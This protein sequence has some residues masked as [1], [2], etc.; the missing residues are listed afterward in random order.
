MR[1]RVRVRVVLVDRVETRDVGASATLRLT[2]QLP[3]GAWIRVS[4]PAAMAAQQRRAY[5]AKLK[6]TPVPAGRR[7]PTSA[8]AAGGFTVAASGR[9][10]GFS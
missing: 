2:L 7:A 8:L 5:Q 1:R 6:A 9:W 4:W 10:I 3:V